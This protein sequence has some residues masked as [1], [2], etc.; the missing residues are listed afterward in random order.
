MLVEPNGDSAE[1]PKL[2]KHTQSS[3]EYHAHSA[4]LVGSDGEN[5]ASITRIRRLFNFSQLFAF[6]LTFMSTWESM[7]TNMFF[8][9]YEGGP[10]VF[11]WSI[12]IVYFGAIAQ[13][14]S[15][16]EMSSTIPIAGAQYHWTY[17]LAPVR[18]RTFIT[19]MQAWMTWF[20][21]ISLL[22]GIANITAIILQQLAILNNPDYLPERWHVTLMMIAIIVVQGLINSFGRTFA[23]IPWLELIAGIM[24]VCLFFVFLVVFAVLGARNSGRQIFLDFQVSS[25]WTNNYVACNLGMKAKHAVP[26]ATFWSIVLNG[27]LAYAMVIA[28]LSAI[29]SVNDVLSS[30]FPVATIILDITG[31][32]RATTAMV[33]GLFIISFCVNI[34]SIASVSRLTWAWSR[35]NGLPPWFALVGPKQMV[36]IRAIWLALFVVMLLSLLNIASTAAFGAITALSSMGL[37]FSYATAISSM[38]FARWEDRYGSERLLLGDWNLGSWGV[39]INIFAL[40]YTL[41]MMVFLPFPSTL[42]ATAL[43]MNYCGPIFGFVF[44]FALASWFLHARQ[45]WKGPVI[46]IVDY[47]KSQE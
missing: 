12:V 6:S 25:G 11:A 16:S 37:Y 7:N 41:Y 30:G 1:S 32:V 44:L 35:D 10:Q 8:A 43:N 42:P 45:H 39:Y 14:A 4:A 34:A 28:I 21:W 18:F 38:L 20:G 36:P 13:A 40:I 47:I 5:L 26:R 31:S 3:T 33:V 46:A 22:A 17:H 23:S 24:H 9:L 29:P 2:E 27:V 19:W 15:I